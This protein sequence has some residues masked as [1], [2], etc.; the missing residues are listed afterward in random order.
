M[1]SGVY[2]R[3]VKRH[4]V[5][6]PLDQSIKLIPLTQG[7]NA[8]VD[9]VD[10]ERL[11]QWDWYANWNVDTQSFYAR[12]CNEE[13]R[14]VWMHHVVL[15]LESG[16][17]GDH[18]NH[19]TLDNRRNNLRECTYAQN[20]QNRRKQKKKLYKGTA[21]HKCTKRW[22]ATICSNRKKTCLGYFK[23]EEEAAHAYDAEARKRFGE[24]AHLNFA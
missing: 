16:K 13:R 2:P 7:Q 18:A 24:F 23:S 15:G 5:T 1:P 4:A 14:H 21:W 3:R 11:S 6:Q 22:V 9:A 10:F 8:I 20:H 17:Y 19:N 12:R